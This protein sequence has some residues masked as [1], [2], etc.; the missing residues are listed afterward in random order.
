MRNATQVEYWKQKQNIIEAVSDKLCGA[1]GMSGGFLIMP[2]G[3]TA[4]PHFHI[5]CESILFVLEGW[6]VAVSGPNLDLIYLGPGDFLFIPNEIVHFGINLSRTHRVVIVEVRN[7]KDFNN[8]LILA[9]D[10][11]SRVDALREELQT[12]F[13]EGKLPLPEGWQNTVGK[14]FFYDESLIES[15]L[16]RSN[17][18]TEDSENPYL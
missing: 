3:K 10:Y 4:S 16:V 7:E 13:E 12:K 9:S 6:L 8:D 5:Y 15:K 11:F 18:L 2:P 14:S 1:K 17:I